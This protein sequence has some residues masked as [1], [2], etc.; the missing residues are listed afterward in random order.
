VAIATVLCV[1]ET[2]WA[3]V[4]ARY[5]PFLTYAVRSASPLSLLGTFSNHHRKSS[6]ELVYSANQVM[7]AYFGRQI[8]AED[9]VVRDMR[10]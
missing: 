8:D 1:D 9:E 4:S 7:D 10:Y 2:S 3:L 6:E 5:L